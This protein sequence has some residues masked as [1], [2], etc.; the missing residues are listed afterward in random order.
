MPF[1]WFVVQINENQAI[2]SF[3]QERFKLEGKIEAKRESEKDR[4]D[5]HKYKT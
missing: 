3:L 2:V 4:D 5:V 1:A